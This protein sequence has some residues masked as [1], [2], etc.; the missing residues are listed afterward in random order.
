[1]GELSAIFISV[2]VNK[3]QGIAITNTLQPFIVRATNELVR[4]CYSQ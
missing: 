3:W 1:M 4:L 2:S